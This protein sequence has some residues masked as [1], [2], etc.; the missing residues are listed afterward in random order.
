[1]ET[2]LP[3]F[4]DL[5]IRAAS[6]ISVC[7]SQFYRWAGGP[8]KPVFGL[9]MWRRR[10]V[11]RFPALLCFRSRCPVTTLTDIPPIF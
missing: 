6:G 4:A 8:L 3:H 11:S 9:I 7:V 10:N 5:F 2:R 1:M